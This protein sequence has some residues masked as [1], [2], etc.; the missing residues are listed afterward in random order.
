MAAV[1]AGGDAAPVIDFDD[2]EYTMPGE[3]AGYV[4][5]PRRVEAWP[6]RTERRLAALEGRVW[7][8]EG[9]LRRLAGRRDDSDFAG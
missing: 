4:P 1:M 8:L 7:R 9:C 2:A 5:E 3:L 6:E